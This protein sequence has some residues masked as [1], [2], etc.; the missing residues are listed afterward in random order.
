M[1]KCRFGRYLNTNNFRYYIEF[2]DSFLK[3]PESLDKLSKAFIEDPKYHKMD[4]TNMINYLLSEYVRHQY[5]EEGKVAMENRIVD[6]YIHD[7]KCLAEVIFKFG[8]YIYKEF[9][10]NIHTCPTL[11]SI[12]LNIYLNKYLPHPLDTDSK[13]ISCIPFIT[14]GIYKDIKNA[15][16]GGHTDVYEMYS[17]EEVHSYDYTSMYPTQ[18]VKWEMPV[19]KVNKFVG[20]PLRIETFDSLCKQHCFMKCTIYVDKSLNRPLYQTLVKIN[21]S[22][23]S[24]CATGTFLNQWIYLPELCKYYELTNGKIRIIPESIQKGY[25]FESKNIFKEYINDMFKI[26]QSVDKSNPMYLISKLLMNSLYGRFGLKQ[27]LSI[28]NFLNPLEIEKLSMGADINIKDVIEFDDLEKSLLITTKGA[29]EVFLKSSVPI[30]AAITARA[31]MELSELLIDEKLD[32]LYIDT[33]SFKCKQKI[34]ELE[35]YKY[36]DHNELGALKYEGT[37]KESIFLLPKVYGG[38]YKESGEE[39]VKVKGFKDKVEFNQLKEIL[40]KNQSLK[41]THDKWYR[42]IMK[43]EIKIMRSSYE[44][45]LNDNKRLIDLKTFK[46]RPYHFDNYNPE[47]ISN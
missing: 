16:H 41:L 27:E 18:M 36:L 44:L 19:G 23:R 34:I 45:S 5:F 6:Y 17:N 33:D 47:N 29:D 35:K 9:N 22:I 11:S 28:Y 4:N 21:G 12:A 37:F 46:T 2:H 10:I 20:N 43:S 31:R 15:Y 38:L 25:L 40:F 7:C 26:K 3:L 39:L 24:V 1:I 14:G 13:D 30:A 32:I 8:F 42:D